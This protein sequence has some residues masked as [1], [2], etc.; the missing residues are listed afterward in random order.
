MS[1]KDTAN[2]GFIPSAYKENKAY[3]IIPTNGN[4]DL[5]HQRTTSSSR[6][7][8]SGIVENVHTNRPTLNYQLNNGVVNGCTAPICFDLIMPPGLLLIISSKLTCPS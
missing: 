1:L 4:G 5:Y 6:I 8:S 2:F 7:D 3:S